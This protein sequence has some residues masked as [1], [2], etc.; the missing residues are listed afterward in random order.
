M[1]TEAKQYLG[2][3]DYAKALPLLEKAAAAGTSD[4]MNGSVATFLGSWP[5]LVKRPDVGDIGGCA[6]SF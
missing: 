2:V 3:D 1:L 6:T 5:L 4:A